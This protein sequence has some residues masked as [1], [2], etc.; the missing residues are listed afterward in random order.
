M[1]SASPRKS[2][3]K[4]GSKATPALTKSLPRHLVIQDNFLAPDLAESLRG[5]FDENFLEP[6]STNIKRFVW[7]YWHVPSQYTLI[8]TSAEDY[9]DAAQY[10]RL[11]SALTDF[12]Q[13]HLGCN[14][15]TKPWLSYY[16]DGCEQRMH[17]DSWHGPFAYVLSLTNWE[18][19]EF[20]GGETF[21][22][23][24]LALDYWRNFDPKVG[25]EEDKLMSTVE[26][27]FNRLTLFDPRIPHGVRAVRGTKDP[28]K[29]RLVLHGWFTDLG[30]PFY[31]AG[32]ISE[33]SAT[34]VLNEAL[35]P[36]YDSLANK[37]SR[38][39]GVLNVRLDVDGATGRVT[40]LSS[41]ADT[42]V[43]DPLDLIE[44]NTPEEVRASVLKE[45]ERHL[46]DLQFDSKG[47]DSSITLPFIFE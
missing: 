8:R 25:L 47:Q 22:M 20:T 15:I 21:L 44:G 13:K 6:R 34:E 41:V 33:E 29:S 19:R 46:K 23:E 12:G 2:V 30:T 45:I 43:A 10:E 38:V 42:M 5:T 31:E 18:E 7:D 24:S 17:T 4:G 35:Q 37:C 27:H 11:T 28:R 9:F 16:V 40:K 39:I 32:G 14:S 36:L 26:P 3:R 1:S